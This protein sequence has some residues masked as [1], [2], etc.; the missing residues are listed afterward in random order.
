MGSRNVSFVI[1]ALFCVTSQL[2]EVEENFLICVAF[3]Q[4]SVRDFFTCSVASKNRRA[5]RGY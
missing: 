2:R 5:L 3:P 1:C 4:L